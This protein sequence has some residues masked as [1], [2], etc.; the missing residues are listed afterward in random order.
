VNDSFDGIQ[1]EMNVPFSFSQSPNTYQKYYYSIQGD[2]CTTNVK[3]N[4]QE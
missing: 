1:L 3:V 4:L 2:V